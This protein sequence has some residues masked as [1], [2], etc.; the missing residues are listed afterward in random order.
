[1]AK[2]CHGTT[3]AGKRCSITADSLLTNDGGRLVAEPLKRGGDSCLYHAKPFCT[4]AVDATDASTVVILLDLE[5][6]GVAVG[7]DRIVEFAALHL[8]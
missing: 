8:S 5:T 3:R 7:S 2:R 1:M 4:R 6:T